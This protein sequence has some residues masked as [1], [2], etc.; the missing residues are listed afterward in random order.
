M[1][2]WEVVCGMVECSGMKNVG[3]KN[4][5]IKIVKQYIV[6]AFTDRI[7]HGN[8]AAVCILDEWLSEEMMLAIACENNL[9]E[10]AFVVPEGDNYRLRWFTPCEE[11]D[12]CGHATLASAYVLLKFYVPKRESVV[13][14]TLGGE[15]T[16]RRKGE[17]LEMEFPAYGLQKVAVTQ[18]M[19]EAIGV[20]PQEAYMGRDLLCV[21][22]NESV[23]CDIQP[24][25]AAVS[26]LPGLLLQVTAPGES[27][28]TDG[29]DCVS[30]TFAP[31]L[32][33]P[34]DPVCGSGH[35]HIVPYWAGRL[36]KQSI[37][38]YQASRRG[39]VLHCRVDGDR[40]FMAGKA[41]M[42]AV[43]EIGIPADETR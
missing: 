9:S 2:D 28:G 37:V 15:L 5:G 42:F 14:A 43:S 21:F 27:S 33:V 20:M 6:D 11:I 30:R 8:P 12:L 24:D 4:D 35:C 10:T 7:F 17:L 16:V 39:G 31:K 36:D 19:A 32:N 23:I 25:M 18:A 13:F 41:V 40:V 26:E 1:D 3:I 29:F 34:E 38:A 22:E